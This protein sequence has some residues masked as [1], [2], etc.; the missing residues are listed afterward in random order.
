ME[1]FPTIQIKRGSTAG[2][3]PAGLTY[4]E[5]AVNVTDAILYVG[6]TTGE[7]IQIVGGGG[8]NNFTFGST[9]P[10]SPS[11]GDIW[12]DSELGSVFFYVDDGNSQQWVEIGGGGGGGGSVGATGATGSQGIQGTPGPTGATGP[13][14]DN[15]TLFIDAT[16]DDI[17]AGNKGYKQIA[18]NCE[19]IE[20]YVISGQTGSIEFDIK[21]SSFANYPSTTSIVGSDYPGLSGAMKDSNTGIT[22]WSGLSA[23][24]MI[25]FVINS[26]TGVQSVGLFIKIR[27]TS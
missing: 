11:A 9:L 16:P 3:V 13:T 12:F 1:I 2:L 26:N 5:L 21:K 23:G 22:A 10:A 14:E 20:W 17:T 27:R 6:G 18:Y 8:G 19:A 7:T 25:D 15:I 4:G 24:D